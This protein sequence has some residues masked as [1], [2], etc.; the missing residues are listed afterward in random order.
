M[1]CGE[2]CFLKI[3]LATMIDSVLTSKADAC[4]YVVLSEVEKHVP[5]GKLVGTTEC[6]ML[7]PRCRI[8]RGHYN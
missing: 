3:M 1:P 6:L 8:D 7:Y 4:M 5:N 2:L